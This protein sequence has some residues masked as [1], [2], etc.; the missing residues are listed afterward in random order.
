[1]VELRRLVLLPLDDLLVITREFINPH[2]SR[3]GLDRCLRRH[4]VGS[5]AETN[6][7]A[8]KVHIRACYELP[9]AAS[10]A[11]ALGSMRMAKTTKCKLAS[12]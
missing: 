8:A 11:A 6:F 1:M 2:A 3:S 4:G 9:A 7:L 5:V 12:T 10:T